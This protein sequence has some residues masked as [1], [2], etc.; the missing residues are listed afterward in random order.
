MQ[1]WIQAVCY[2]GS[3]RCLISSRL[4]YNIAKTLGQK[5]G[6]ENDE[7]LMVEMGEA[8]IK[9]DCFTDGIKGVLTSIGPD[10]RYWLGIF[11]F[12]SECMMGQYPE[13]KVMNVFAVKLR[14]TNE[15]CWIPPRLKKLML[16]LS[17]PIPF[18]TNIIPNK[19]KLFWKDVTFLEAQGQAVCHANFQLTFHVQKGR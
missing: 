1:S 10:P 14:K 18:G 5:V 17:R 6:T 19:L 9:N 11:P 15:Y 4:A 8:Q 7:P 12:I 13:F 2:H 16:R 3:L